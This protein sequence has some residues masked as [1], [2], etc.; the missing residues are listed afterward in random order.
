AVLSSTVHQLWAIKYG[1]GMKSD[2]RYTPSDVFDTFPRPQ[3][4]DALSWVGETLERER[5]EVML[6]R[7]LGLT[8]LYNIVN[9]A[10]VSDS[11]DADVA[12]L[13]TIHIELDD[14]VMDA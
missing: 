5:R 10:A 1:S 6:R 11:A 2:P 12:R 14:A 13:R 3:P 7:S 4:S 9:D 8:K